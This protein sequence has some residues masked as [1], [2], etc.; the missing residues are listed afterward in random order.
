[1]IRKLTDNLFLSTTGATIVQDMSGH[2]KWANI[3]RKKGVNDAKRG[4]EFSKLARLI[5]VAAKEGGGD[6]GTNPRL[7]LV[8]DKAKSA[9]M[10]KEN[11]LRAIDRGTGKGSD[12]E[13]LVEVIFEGYGPNGEAFLAKGITDNINRTVSEIRLLF[14]KSDG[15]LGGEGSTAY[16][17]GDDPES[18]TFKIYPSEEEIHKLL[19][20]YGALEEHDDVMSVFVNFDL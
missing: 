2:S 6:V 9:K 3:K 19:S 20:L 17:F 5:T 14:N 13:N 4:K 18:P 12:S 8:V 1:M 7:R 10:P 16:I 11:I 15:N